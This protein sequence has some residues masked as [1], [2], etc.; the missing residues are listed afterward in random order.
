[1][2]NE[3]FIFNIPIVLVSGNYVKKYYTS[4][5]ATIQDKFNPYNVLKVCAYAQ[6]KHKG[7]TF[8]F[9]S[10]CDVLAYESLQ[11]LSQTRGGV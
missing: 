8:R 1:M 6:K 3:N 7:Q 10:D 4:A 11:E 9:A 5:Y 2:R